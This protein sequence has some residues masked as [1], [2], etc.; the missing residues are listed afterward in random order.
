MDV[1]SGCE[2]CAG[3]NGQQGATPLKS[4]CMEAY[5]KNDPP[6]HLIYHLGQQ[7]PNEFMV[8]IPTLKS[9]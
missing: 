6:S 1:A 4:D 9:S 7:F 8:S 2:R 5:E 3:V